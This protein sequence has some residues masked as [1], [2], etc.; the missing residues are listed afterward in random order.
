MAKA[1]ELNRGDACPNCGG[2]LVAARVPTDEEF[3]K[4]F[5]RENPVALPPYTDTANPD[6]R[7]E[8]GELHICHDCGYKARFE[9]ESQR[10]SGSSDRGARN[11]DA[12]AEIEASEQ[13][14]AGEGES[15]RPNNAGRSARSSRG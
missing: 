14:V 6:Q 13:R 11:P 2:E 8:L 4:A 15:S 10:S 7:E 3:R 5:D 9:A 12:N 1:K